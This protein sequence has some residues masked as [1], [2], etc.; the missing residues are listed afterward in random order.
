M[1]KGSKKRRCLVSREE[2]DLRWSL[3]MGYI[4]RMTFDEAMKELKNAKK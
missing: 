4:T 3:F 2:E 1:G